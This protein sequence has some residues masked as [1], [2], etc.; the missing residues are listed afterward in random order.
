MKEKLPDLHAGASFTE[1]RAYGKRWMGVSMSDW[2]NHWSKNLTFP[3]FKQALVN[4]NAPAIPNIQASRN[5][6]MFIEGAWAEYTRRVDR[7]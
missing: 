4:A 7:R 5:L 6:D 1:Y 3:E 2:S